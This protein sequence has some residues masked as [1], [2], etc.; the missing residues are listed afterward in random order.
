MGLV[1]VVSLAGTGR[2]LQRMRGHDEDVYDLSWSPLP[3][4]AVAVS[5]RAGDPAGG[6]RLGQQ[7][8]ILASASRDKTVKLWGTMAGKSIGSVRLP[9]N[10]GLES[11]DNATSCK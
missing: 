5:G 4:V 7:E 11:A 1:F 10:S 3:G 2:V 6:D 8:W 9:S